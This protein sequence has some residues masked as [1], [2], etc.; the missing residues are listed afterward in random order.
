MK[1]TE[2]D[3][4]FNFEAESVEEKGVLKTLAHHAGDD[5]YELRL[6]SYSYDRNDPTGN[7]ISIR[8]GWEKTSLNEIKNKIKECLEFGV[9]IPMEIQERYNKLIK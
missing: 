3:G 1:L 2:K 7:V 6:K 8:F 4:L 9:P 5:C